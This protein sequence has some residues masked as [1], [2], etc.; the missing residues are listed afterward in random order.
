MRYL[1]NLCLNVTLYYYNRNKTSK[2]DGVR[3]LCNQCVNVTLYYYNRNKTSKHEGLSNACDHWEYS[4]TSQYDLK[5]HKMKYYSRTE[6]CGAA[7]KK[8]KL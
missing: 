1:Y 3:Y 8:I 4:I 2:H 7:A 6:E 5:K